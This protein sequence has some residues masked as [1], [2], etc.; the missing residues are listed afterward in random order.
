VRS[1]F[2]TMQPHV[3][4]LCLG[5]SAPCHCRSAKE[6]AAAISS[7][8]RLPG[9]K[10]A[11]A[12]ME[13]VHFRPLNFRLDLV[14]TIELQNRVTSTIQLLKLFTFDH[15]VVLLTW[16]P[17]GGKVHLSALP[18][19]SLSSLT[20]S[21]SLSCLISLLPSDGRAGNRN[22]TSESNN[23]EHLRVSF[24]FAF[25]LSFFTT[26]CPLYSIVHEFLTNGWA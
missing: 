12:T 3:H 19:P 23:E 21:L 8:S 24:T 7:P 1:S 14:L 25:W 2:L 26:Y 22:V 5:C 9:Q 20:L 4:I 15:P 16:T 10:V 11:G 17:R 18:P 13:K 6:D